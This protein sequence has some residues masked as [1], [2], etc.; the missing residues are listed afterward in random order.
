MPQTRGSC[1]HIKGTYDNHPS[2]INCC[3]CCRFHGCSVCNAWSDVAD[4]TVVLCAT[5]GPTLLG[6]W[7]VGVDF[8]VTDQWTRRKRKRRNKGSPSLGIPLVQDRV[9]NGLNRQT[10]RGLLL[11]VQMM[12][13]H[14]LCLGHHRG[15]GER[16][17]GSTQVP[18]IAHTEHRVR[19]LRRAVGR[20]NVPP[21][22]D[23]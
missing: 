21:P 13:S 9:L 2:C 20:P 11:K 12:T 10:R 22:P 23:P 5:L 15:G 14:Q 16:K 18:S 1:G 4:F 6:I 3:G 19:R 8:T 17:H 7:S